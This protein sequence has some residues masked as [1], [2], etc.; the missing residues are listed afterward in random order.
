LSSTC[1]HSAHSLSLLATTMMTIPTTMRFNLQSS[2][3]RRVP[4][5]S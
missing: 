5:T 4:R 1:A 3:V 2:V